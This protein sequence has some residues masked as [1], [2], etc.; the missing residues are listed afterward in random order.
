MTVSKIHIDKLMVTSG[1]SFGTSGAR[2][3]VRD[4]TDRLCYIYTLA[5]LQHLKASAGLLPGSRVAVAGDFR[6]STPRIMAAVAAA[7]SD[8]GFEPVNCGHI[9]TPAVAYYGIREKIPSIMVTGS[10]IPDDRNGIKFNTPA[11]EI[12]KSDETGIRQQQVSIDE[13]MF[14]SAGNLL[15]PPA[16]SQVDTDASRQYTK[17][18]QDFFPTA[19]LQGMKIGLYEHSTVVR[20]A[21]FEVLSQLGAQVIKLGYSD[22][23]LPVDTEAVRSED[24]QLAK[25]WSAEHRLDAIVS[26]D[27]DGD[28]PLIS[29]ENGE[30]LRGDVVGVLAAD[31][32]HANVAVTPVSSNTLVEK[33]GLFDEVV[34][35]RIGSPYVIAEMQAAEQCHPGKII[36]GYEANGGFLTGTSICRDAHTLAPLPTRDCIL[37]IISILA[38]SNETKSPISARLQQLPARYTF[39]DRIKDFPTEISNQKLEQFKIAD[40]AAALRNIQE[41]LGEEFPAPVDINVIDGVRITL[42]DDDII[43][44]RPSGNAPELRCYTESSSPERAAGINHKVISRLSTWRTQ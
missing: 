20:D 8:S 21:L 43:H 25:Q 16:M 13:S 10:H 39:S 33:S 32:L 11:G 26:A 29:D 42:S 30:W 7:I 2:G 35:S 14:D 36:I 9:A 18:Y 31:Y 34:R 27:G 17:R 1:V 23:F 22:S 15:A 28:R 6:P 41:F 38:M 40:T 19:C 24:I 37:P 3:L 5:F 12:L 44:F 4:M